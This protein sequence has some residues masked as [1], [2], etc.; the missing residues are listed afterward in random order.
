MSTTGNNHNESENG[1]SIAIGVLFSQSGP[2]AVTEKAHLK[3]TLMAI[4]EINE[5]GGID[6]VP[7]RPIIDDPKSDPII[8]RKLANKLL[9]QDQVSVIFGCCSS[10]TRKAVLPIVERHGGLLFYPSFYE[11][12]EFSPNIVYTG[13]TPNQTVI[14]LVE[15]L[16]SKY[17]KK[18]GLVGSDYIFPHEINRIVKEFLVESNGTVTT[19]IYVPQGAKYERFQLAAEKLVESGPSVILSTVVGEDTAKLYESCHDSGV[20]AQSCPIASLTTSESELACMSVESRCGQITALP[21][22]QSIQTPENQEFVNRYKSKYRSGDLPCVYS[23]TT[24]SQ[25]RMLAR[26]LTRVTNHSPESLLN[27]IHGTQ[28]EA[29]QGSIMVDPENNHTYVTPRIGR[30]TEKGTF[31]VL[32]QAPAPIKPDPYLVAYDRTIVTI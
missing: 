9:T 25:V 22:F 18:F 7:I 19:E 8:S 30:S 21:Y 27:A 2:M 32:W 26:A 28:F 1:S 24:Y 10:A 16:F 5:D 20:G 6:G 13:A 4:D 29:P 23:E 14:P 12:F 31:E 3:G 15:F 17:G 11:G